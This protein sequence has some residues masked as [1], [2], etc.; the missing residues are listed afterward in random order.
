[1]S[2]ASIW[3]ALCK[4]E[5][6]YSC[7]PCWGMHPFPIWFGLMKGGTQWETQEM[8]VCVAKIAKMARGDQSAKDGWER[9][10]DDSSSAKSLQCYSLS[11]AKT[12]S[13]K[14]STA[15]QL[16][17]CRVARGTGW[18]GRAW[19]GGAATSS[20]TSESRGAVQ[21]RQQPKHGE[22]LLSGLA[23]RMR[24]VARCEPCTA[25]RHRGVDGYEKVAEFLDSAARETPIEIAEQWELY[26]VDFSCA[27]DTFARRV[28]VA[29]PEKW[30]E[31][32]GF[33]CAE[34]RATAYAATGERLV[35][36]PE[37]ELGFEAVEESG[38]DGLV[39]QGRVGANWP[40]RGG[41]LVMLRRGARIHHLA[42]SQHTD[43]VLCFES[44]EPQE[45]RSA[46]DSHPRRRSLA[47]YNR[48]EQRTFANTAQSLQLEVNNDKSFRG[49]R[50]TFC[51]EWFSFE[52]AMVARKRVRE[53]RIDF[54]D[55]RP[56][57]VGFADPIDTTLGSGPSKRARKDHPPPAKK[58]TPPP[59]IHFC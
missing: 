47:L 25:I 7:S 17:C 34:E 5:R 44:R 23:P 58:Y 48:Q 50:G 40:V 57:G 22:P 13:A 27:S 9:S 43:T 29:F 53:V 54:T 32:F 52:P 38:G 45:N 39:Y 18:C 2:F 31:H 8:V 16:K 51:Q 6:T 21:E 3:S 1:M 42:N 41:S 59:L 55:T 26:S 37:H 14:E 35:W 33:S 30:E 24:R 19:M 46:K 36:I 15:E 56:V 20:Q 49:P 12:K 28:T 11:K 10:G 4:S